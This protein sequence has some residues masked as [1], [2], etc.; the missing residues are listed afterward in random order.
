MWEDLVISA[1]RGNLNTHRRCRGGKTQRDA[2]YRETCDY[3]SQVSRE[4]R[5]IRGVESRES[6]TALG[7]ES[8]KMAAP[9]D[10]GSLESRI[11]KSSTL[12]IEQLYNAPQ[13]R[14]NT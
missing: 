1:Q 5:V 13:T 9:P 2:A 11:S 6:W 12:L 3:C 7:K 14:D 4:I 10:E 8:R